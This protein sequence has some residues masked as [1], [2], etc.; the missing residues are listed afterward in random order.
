MQLFNQFFFR[1]LFV[2]LYFHFCIEWLK[3]SSSMLKKNLANIITIINLILGLIAIVYAIDNEFLISMVF[4]LEAL[5]IFISC[6]LFI[7]VT[8]S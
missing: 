6:L 1:F 8:M 5:I 7:A 4:I 2:K 3:A